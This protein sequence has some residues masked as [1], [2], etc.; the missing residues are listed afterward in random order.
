LTK[1]SE[2]NDMVELFDM[3]KGAAAFGDYTKVSPTNLLK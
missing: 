2:G 3:K 1:G